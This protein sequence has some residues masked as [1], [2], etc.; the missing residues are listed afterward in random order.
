[1]FA[2]QTLTCLWQKGWGK[3]IYWASKSCTQSFLVIVS[4][5]KHSFSL[6]CENGTS[7]WRWQCH[8]HC[9]LLM[10]W[11]IRHIW[12]C[13]LNQCA[14]WKPA[15]NT[16]KRSKAETHYDV[17]TFLKLLTAQTGRSCPWSPLGPWSLKYCAP[18]PETISSCLTWK[19][20]R[21]VNKTGTHLQNSRKIRRA[22][23]SCHS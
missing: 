6:S 2:S 10:F 1:V 14:T 23:D 12:G 9:L 4:P 22:R 3:K 19:Q 18:W 16:H 21:M 11:S 20:E 5:S 13:H 17:H 7:H 15:H 8:R